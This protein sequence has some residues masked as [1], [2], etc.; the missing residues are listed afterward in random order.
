M[1][2]GDTFAV[3][4]RA[5]DRFAAILRQHF[6]ATAA[7]IAIRRIGWQ[8]NPLPITVQQVQAILRVREEVH[9]YCFPPV[10]SDLYFPH[11]KG[12]FIL[13]GSFVFLN[14]AAADTANVHHREIHCHAPF[15]VSGQ[16]NIAL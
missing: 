1:W 7:H 4:R 6:P 2:L 11:P 13:A 12:L 16:P 3:A 15:A 8:L 5:L 14:P 9:L 10:A